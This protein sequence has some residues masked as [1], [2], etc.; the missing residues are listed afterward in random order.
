MQLELPQGARFI[1]ELQGDAQRIS[2]ATRVQSRWRMLRCR[3]Q[4]VRKLAGN[5]LMK[6]TLQ[7]DPRWDAAGFHQYLISA[8]ADSGHTFPRWPKKSPV[9][10]FTWV[11]SGKGFA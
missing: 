9:D 6:E 3:R 7:P 11:G 4:H 2:A 5:E 10:G 1:N 8:W